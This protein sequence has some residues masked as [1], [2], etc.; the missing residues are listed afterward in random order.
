[1]CWF[2]S[3][4]NLKSDK[5]QLKIKFIKFTKLLSSNCWEIKYIDFINWS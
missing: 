5:L 2:W 3:S 1:M 4:L